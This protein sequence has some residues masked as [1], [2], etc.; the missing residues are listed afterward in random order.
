MPPN[1]AL[2]PTALRSGRRLSLAVR[3]PSVDEMK[4]W[5]VVSLTC[6]TVSL[7]SVAFIFTTP[8]RYPDFI[9]V[10]RPIVIFLVPLA[11]IVALLALRQT[12]PHYRF[13]KALF[14]AAL[15]FLA[16]T[17][18][19][20]MAMPILGVG[21]IALLAMFIASRALAGPRAHA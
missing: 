1:I 2:E 16:L 3:P 5:R 8:L 21:L 7:L 20:Y 9:F 13:V 4:T 12:W 11:V 17:A 10:W 19:E 15:L 18:F 14:V 6:Y